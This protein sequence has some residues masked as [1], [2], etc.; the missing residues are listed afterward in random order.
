MS[1]FDESRNGSA[2][3]V[4]FGRIYWRF[5]FLRLLAFVAIRCLGQFYCLRIIDLLSSGCQM[6]LLLESHSTFESLLELDI[7]LLGVPRQ[8]S[9]CFEV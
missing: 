8:R 3:I 5:Y 4:L 1:L 7:W 2:T 9:L 6:A